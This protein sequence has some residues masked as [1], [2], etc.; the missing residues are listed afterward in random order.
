[1]KS[2]L[3]IMVVVSVI[4]LV[5]LAIAFKGSALAAGPAETKPNGFTIGAQGCFEYMLAPDKVLI[6]NTAAQLLADKETMLAVTKAQVEQFGAAEGKALY[7][8]LMKIGPVASVRLAAHSFAVTVQPFPADTWGATLPLVL[9]EI[10]ET[11]D[12]KK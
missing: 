3:C 4:A 7:G 5:F 1:M 11:L 6:V 10:R 2:L 9:K 8:R 12:C